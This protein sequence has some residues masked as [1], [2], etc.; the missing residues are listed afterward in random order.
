LDEKHDKNLL[1]AVTI[2]CVNFIGFFLTVNPQL[3]S[4]EN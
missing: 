3:L 4:K 2:S 1:L